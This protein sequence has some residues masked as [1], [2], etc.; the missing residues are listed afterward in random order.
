MAEKL[1]Q[2]KKKGGGNP[3]ETVLW[4]NS[5][6]TTSQAAVTLNLSESIENFDYIKIK[7][8]NSTTNTSSDEVLYPIEYVK[9][10]SR[11]ANNP[12]MII[13]FFDSSLSYFFVRRIYYSSNTALTTTAAY[14]T[15][16]SGTF[17]NYSIVTEISGVKF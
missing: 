13:G 14:T 6:P 15:G 2:L 9:K 16:G 8:R 7:A 5:S 12:A 3:K 11:T 1:C 17:N 4:T 10:S